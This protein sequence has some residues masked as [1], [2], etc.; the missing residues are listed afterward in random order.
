MS[1]ICLDKYGKL[2]YTVKVPVWVLSRAIFD[3]TF[4]TN[5][6]YGLGDCH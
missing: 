1:E 5:P 4:L 6:F 2:C 3:P